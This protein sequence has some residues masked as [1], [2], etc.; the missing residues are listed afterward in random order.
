M[1]FI[2][3]FN[4]GEKTMKRTIGVWGISS[5]EEHLLQCLLQLLESRTTDA[6]ALSVPNKAEVVIVNADTAAERPDST[7]QIVVEYSANGDHEKDLVLHRPIR[8]GELL[9]LLNRLS[10]TLEANEQTVGLRNRT[11]GSGTGS[12]INRPYTRSIIHR[13]RNRLGISG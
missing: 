6:W 12:P 13:I 4:T 3:D 1:S 10:D 5:H 11:D 9:R 8:S 7:G 2:R